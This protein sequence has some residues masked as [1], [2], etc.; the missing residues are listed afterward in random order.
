VN[1]LPLATCLDRLAA[2][3]ARY[4]SDELRVDVIQLRQ[5][6]PSSG[7]L[8]FADVLAALDDWT[9]VANHS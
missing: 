5:R 2:V 7:G 6:L 3:F 9:P 1:G 8:S 4:G